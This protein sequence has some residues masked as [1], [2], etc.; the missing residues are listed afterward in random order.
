VAV[1]I[2][3]EQEDAATLFDMLLDALDEGKITFSP[4]SWYTGLSLNK[5]NTVVQSLQ[6]WNDVDGFCDS[7]DK[8]VMMDEESMDNMN[9]SNN[10]YPYSTVLEYLCK[11]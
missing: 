8:E 7:Y 1:M 9:T 2:Q 5:R 11:F 6:R 4:W 3:S 10:E